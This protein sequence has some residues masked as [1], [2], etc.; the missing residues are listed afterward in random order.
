MYR[1]KSGSTHGLT[2]TAAFIE[3]LNRLP[4]HSQNEYIYWG[5]LR[6]FF[7]AGREL[8]V[9]RAPGRLDLMGGIADY[10]GSLVL[11]LPIASATHVAIQLQEQ[12]SLRIVSLP[13]GRDGQ[14]RLFEMPLADFLDLGRPVE[15]ATAQARFMRTPER[16][17]AAYVA[18]AFLVL[19]RERGRVFNEG[20][21]ILIH[22]AVP[23]GKGVSSSAALEVAAMQAITAAYAID[24]VPREAAFLC[25]RVENLVAGAPCGVMDQMTSA[26]GEAD[27]L[28]ALLCQ[29]GELLGTVAMPGELAVWG[30]DSGIRH[31]VGGADYGTVRTAAFMGYRMIAHM[32]GL[33]C[34]ETEVA[35]HVRIEDARW[36]GY[37][38]N[39]TPAEFDADYAAGLPEQM[40]G[41]E[42]LAA[43][44][45][46]T[47]PVTSVSPARRYPVRQAT[48]HPIYEHARVKSFAEILKNWRGIGQAEELGELMFQSHKSYSACG[49]GSPGTDEL[50][51]LVREA[52][53]KAGL[54]GAKI[55]GGGSGGTV[56]VLGHA[57]A[58]KAVE[59]IATEYAKS[60]T[61]LRR[62][63][64]EP[65][66]ISGSSPG[67]GVFGHLRLVKEKSKDEG[68]KG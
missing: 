37:L 61:L 40:S 57:E 12:E 14:P 55:T 10:S 33:T 39:I 47:D 7:E 56:A 52:G 45:G 21:R 13:L 6:D 28:L 43:Y 32:A 11:E 23:E 1:L 22:S 66:I 67:A 20:A 18:G 63:G 54:Y 64:H 29:P 3:L 24:I 16:H 38:A 36:Q 44:G 9:S 27:R 30:I 26:C 60:I 58:G 62:A 41:A 49:L 59:A 34:H 50:V 51:R 8:I 35:G 48:A 5:E 46:I 19:M 68:M 31:S 15:Y 53:G 42:F 4:E 25:Q 17:W 65:F 2:D